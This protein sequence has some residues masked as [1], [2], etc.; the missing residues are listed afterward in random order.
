MTKALGMVDGASEKA[1]RIRNKD[2][3]RAKAAR[4]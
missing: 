1:G 4:L 2:G 3:S